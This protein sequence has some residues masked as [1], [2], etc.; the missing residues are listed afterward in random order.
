MGQGACK[1][2]LTI[3]KKRLTVCPAATVVA[4]CWGRPK[5]PPA[6]TNDNENP[7]K[8]AIWCGPRKGLKVIVIKCH[9][10]TRCGPVNKVRAQP[11]WAYVPEERRIF[12]KPQLTCA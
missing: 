7:F 11:V 10:I 4:A 3:L 2:Y 6:K 12:S 8:N 5:G 9:D 1:K